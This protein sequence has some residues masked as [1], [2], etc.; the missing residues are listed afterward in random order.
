MF[1]PARKAAT[2]DEQ[3][4]H[5]QYG[6]EYETFVKEANLRQL[7]RK[8]LDFRNRVWKE[9]MEKAQARIEEIDREKEKLLESMQTM[10]QARADW[11]AQNAVAISREEDVETLRKHEDFLSMKTDSLNI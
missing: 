11:N 10:E 9:E 7:K 1:G 5:A 4:R 6:S 3:L 2:Q 8:D